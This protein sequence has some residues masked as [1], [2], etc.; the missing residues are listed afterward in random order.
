ME[1]TFSGIS[2]ESAAVLTLRVCPASKALANT[3]TEAIATPPPGETL[4][5]TKVGSTTIKMRRHIR[6]A[7]GP[8]AGRYI[9]SLVS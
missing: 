5:V 3:S 7:R 9:Y 6:F 8:T 2:N 4:A 1:L